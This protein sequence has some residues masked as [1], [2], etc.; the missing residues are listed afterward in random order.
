MGPEKKAGFFRGIT[1]L[2]KAILGRGGTL[3][4]W[5]SLQLSGVGISSHPGGLI[6]NLGGSGILKVTPNF[7]SLRDKDLS[8]SGALDGLREFYMISL[9]SQGQRATG[10][11]MRVIQGQQAQSGVCGL[12]RSGDSWDHSESPRQ[13]ES[14][15]SVSTGSN[16]QVA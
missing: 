1:R 2:P 8:G 15:F 16:Q 12:L 10:G 14:L 13:S 7:T 5:T 6:V 3:I 4:C 11:H 9:V